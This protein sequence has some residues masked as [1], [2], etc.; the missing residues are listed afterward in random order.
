MPLSTITSLRGKEGR[1]ELYKRE[2]EREEEEE[3]EEEEELL[4]P[5]Q[6]LAFPLPAQP[7]SYYTGYLILTSY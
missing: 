4:F 1:E 7:T 5:C 3:E 2:R 6:F